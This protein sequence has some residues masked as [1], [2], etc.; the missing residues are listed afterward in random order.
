M[1]I[2]LDV[3]QLGAAL[4]VAHANLCGVALDIE[5]E[6]STRN[7]LVKRIVE[8]ARMKPRIQLA[9]VPSAMLLA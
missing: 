3:P 2:P 1:A 8:L 5:N 4:D 6:N 9:V 7:W